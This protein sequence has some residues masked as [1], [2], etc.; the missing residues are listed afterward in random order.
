MQNSHPP[1][2]LFPGIIAALAAGIIVALVTPGSVTSHGSGPA[3]KDGTANYAPLNH[4]KDP[5]DLAKQAPAR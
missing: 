3:H 1:R 5:A 2:W 4:Y